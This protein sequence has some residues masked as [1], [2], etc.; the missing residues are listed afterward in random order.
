MN[1][2]RNIYDWL[3]HAKK[4]P[5]MF[6][7]DL[8]DLQSRIGGYYT[9]LQIHNIT[10]DLPSLTTGCF[11]IWLQEKTG[12]S[13]C[14]GWKVAFDEHVSDEKE[15]IERFF[16]FIDEYQTI[17]P[18]EIGRVSLNENN[19]PTGQRVKYGCNGLMEQPNTIIAINYSPTHLN[20]MR[21]LYG[22]RTEDDF[23]LMLT[24]GSYQ[25]TLSDLMEWAYDEFRV[26]KSQ[27]ELP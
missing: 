23:F 1:H 10:E 25:T 3:D 19:R 4:L 9:A 11:S 18:T 17:T 15:K 6:F 8:D 16:E 21:F 7:R 13:M 2:Y 26:E 20:H 22:D 14:G 24:N 12:W 5:A 27:W